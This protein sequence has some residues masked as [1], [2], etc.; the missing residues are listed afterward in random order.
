MNQERKSLLLFTVLAACFIIVDYFSTIDTFLIK[1]IPSLDGIINNGSVRSTF[2]Q[3]GMIIRGGF[4]LMFLFYTYNEVISLALKKSDFNKSQYIII[5]TLSSV[6]FGSAFVFIR[7]IE[8]YFKLEGIDMAILYIALWVL[9][10]ISCYHFAKALSIRTKIQGDEIDLNGEDKPRGMISLRTTDNRYINVIN[11]YQGTLVVGSA[12]SG[13][14]ASVGHPILWK[15][16][17]QGFSGVVYSYKMFDLANVVTT[18]FHHNK[19]G[20]EGVSLRI[21]NF[22]DMHRTN[23]VNPLHPKYIEEESYLD[24]YV[25]CIA[26]NLNKE[27]IKKTDFFAKSTML[28]LKAVFTF[29]KNKH[30]E[31]CT[32]PHAFALVNHL[33]TNEIIELLKN[34]LKSKIISSSFAEGVD[35]K[36]GDQTAGVISSIKN[37]TLPLENEKMFWVLSEDEVDLHLNNPDN[38]T[39]LVLVNNPQTEDTITPIISLMVTVARKLMNVPGKAPSIFALDEAPT[40]FIPNFDTLPAT[41]RSNK[42]AVCFMC[43]DLSQME[44]MYDKVGAQNIR[45]S[46]SNVFFGNSSEQETQKYVQNFF[47]KVDKII[48]N[49]SQGANK[50]TGSIGQSNNLS[51]NTQERF[52]I[53]DSEVNTFKIGEFAGKVVGNDEKPFFKVRFDLLENETKIKP[54]EIEVPEFSLMDESTGKRLDAVQIIKENYDKIISDVY[55]LKE[56]YAPSEYDKHKQ[57]I[58]Q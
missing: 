42:I 39:M 18:A 15:T 24:E 23:R 34:D 27:W 3:Q 17:S 43:Q 54:D 50:S 6:V 11:L 20:T 8:A 13:K 48:E 38:K 53:K 37:M 28:L 10:I 33:G 19:K 36:A 7:E 9:T 26:L 41:G 31:Y 30:P 22:T 51:Y 52:L 35:Q 29:L 44:K 46:L 5:S 1:Y 57:Y 32:I 2:I 45:G 12:G 40:L 21:V 25:R 16:I 4:I 49:Q 14:T 47:G 58:N 56:M 55:R